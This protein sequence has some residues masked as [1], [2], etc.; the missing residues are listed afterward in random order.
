MCPCHLTLP[1]LW[2]WTP[3]EGSPVGGVAAPLLSPHLCLSICLSSKFLLLSFIK[4]I[5]T[6]DP[7]GPICDA[8]YLA[9]QDY[10]GCQ[11]HTHLVTKPGM[12]HL[13]GQPVLNRYSCIPGDLRLSLAWD[14][15]DL[16]SD[17][18]AM[19]WANETT[20]KLAHTH[21]YAA[22]WVQHGLL[23]EP[24]NI[25]MQVRQSLPSPPTSQLLSDTRPSFEILTCLSFP[26]W[27]S[28]GSD[29]EY[30]AAR[31]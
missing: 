17:S 18:W 30:L 9:T 24:A 25:K 16:V 21:S 14:Q 22:P 27:L 12:S 19:F 3:I 8:H 26:L 28:P 31:C 20:R 5:L 23:P 2:V 10:T 6:R 15:N 7:F 11:P 1:W 13:V 4:P 29:V